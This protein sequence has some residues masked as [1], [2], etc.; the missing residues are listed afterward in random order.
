MNLEQMLKDGQATLLAERTAEKE[1]KEKR[2]AEKQQ[3]FNSAWDDFDAKAK[4]YLPAE[5]HEF[6]VSPRKD[7]KGL[8]SNGSHQDYHFIQ[9]DIPG[10][11]RIYFGFVTFVS[12]GM[13]KVLK[14]SGNWIS[15]V[16]FNLCSD[17]QG[18]FETHKKETR[19][20]VAL[21]LAREAWEQKEELAA[22]IEHRQEELYRQN[23]ALLAEREEEQKLAEIDAEIDAR[24]TREEKVYRLF[25]E[26]LEAMRNYDNE[27]DLW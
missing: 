24:E 4:A 11:T 14:S 13:R 27:G 26:L 7:K 15:V 18:M 17:E 23:Q 22:E 1:R 19:I 9:I 21:A 8:P 25:S 20:P 3:E 6:Y 16:N 12:D 2:L 5:L 10:Y